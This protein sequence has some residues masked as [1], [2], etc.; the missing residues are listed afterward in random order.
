M[1]AQLLSR[2]YTLGVQNRSGL[3]EDLLP[4]L[5]R[6]GKAGDGAAAAVGG[7]AVFDDDGADDDGEVHGARRIATAYAAKLK[8]AGY[9][10]LTTEI[11]AHVDYY[12]AEEEHQQYLHK[13]PGG[14]CPVHATGITCG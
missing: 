1:L 13:N 5:L 3:D 10:E 9:G 7:D 6:I 14:Y 8:E 11:R 12:L 2:C 4:L